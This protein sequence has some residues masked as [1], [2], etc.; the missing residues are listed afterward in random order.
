MLNGAVV[1]DADGHVLEPRSAWASLS[2]DHRP[3]ISTDSG[4]LDHVTVGGTEVFVA[5]LGQMGTPGTDVGA[6]VGPVPLEAARPGAF[7][8]RARLDDMDREGID[9]AVLYPTIGLGFWGISDPEAAVAV[10][11][12]YNDWL[13]GYCSAS[14]D[15]LYGAAMVPMQDVT[16]AVEE[17]R[18]ASRELDFVSVFVRPNPC[19]GRTLVDPAHEPFWEA[20]EALGV[21][22][23]VHEGFQMAVPPI[24]IERRPTNVLI[25]HAISHTFEQMLACAQ[26]IGTGVL[27]RHPGLRIVFLEAGGGWAPYW[28]ARLDHQVPSYHRFAPKLSLLPSEYFARQ[29]WVSFEIDEETLPALLPYVGEDRVVWGSDYPHADSTFPGAVEELARTV[30]SLDWKSQRRIFGENASSLYGIPVRRRDDPTGSG[31]GG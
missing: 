9:K 26:L 14:P 12:A 27:E 21:A 3:V 28:L 2:D 6:P 1:F 18:R 29:C 11:R 30:E 8:P 7:D 19:C 16:A 17:L 23:A 5:R 4:G 24:G 31:S 15:R 13:A 22:V 10:A 25:L 20:A